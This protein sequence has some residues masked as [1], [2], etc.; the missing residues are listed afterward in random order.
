MTHHRV[1]RQSL[2]LAAAGGL[3]AA[4]LG[5]GPAT[6]ASAAGLPLEP[7]E[8]VVSTFGNLF[9]LPVDKVDPQSGDRSRIANGLP[10][11][12]N[13]VTSDQSGN[14]FVSLRDSS[15][16]RIDRFTG[17]QRRIVVAGQGIFVQDMV[18]D[19]SGQLIV[20]GQTATGP[21]LFSVDPNSGIPT[22]L[23]QNQVFGKITSGLALESDG[24][25]L[26]ADAGNRQIVR[27]DGSTHTASKLATFSAG[28]ELGSLIVA[29]TGEILVRANLSDT[30][31][32]PALVRVD[33][34]T[35][36]KQ[37]LFKDSAH[38]RTNT[39]MARNEEGTIY[40][41]ERGLEDRTKS[42]VLVMSAP[43]KS[44]TILD[45]SGDSDSLDV[46]VAGHRQ[47][48]PVPN[49]VGVA[50]RFTLEQPIGQFESPRS[51]LS[52]D[53]N[54]A[55]TP[56][57]AEKV[58]EVSHG[59][60][61]FFSDGRFF[62]FP[63]SGF[64]GT[65]TLT[66]RVRAGNRLSAPTTVTFTVLPP[67]APVAKDDFFL[68]PFGKTLIFE[69]DL[70]PLLN[71]S[72]PQGDPVSARV[73][74]QAQHGLASFD[75]DNTM[76]YLP[77]ANFSGTDSFTYQLTDGKH[78]SNIATVT[79]TVGNPPPAN[80]APSIAVSTG[81]SINS[82]GTGATVKLTISDPETG[83]NL[84]GLA[85]S[86]SNTGLLPS[87]GLV[88]GGTANARTLTVT[89]KA[90]AIGTATVTV[91]VTD[92]GGLKKSLPVTVKVD[93]GGDHTLA[94]TEGTDVLFGAGG[95]DTLSGAGGIDLLSGAAGDDTMTG[96]AGADVFR[97]GTGINKVTDL[98]T[99]EGDSATEV[100]P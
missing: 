57:T 45:R 37:V 76:A 41:T 35:G 55:G 15:I 99:A 2:A 36:L 53:L 100:T 27:V 13:K 98:K 29:D 32:T 8:L 85:A 67:Q 46:T 89:P 68:T 34:L 61:S 88:F 70:G 77:A 92:G 84:L 3:V 80:K 94:G 56:M 64:S 14:V 66:Y 24:D 44:V 33:P 79:I 39:G 43:F 22:L 48:P 69:P 10:E 50:D 81:G 5:L 30:A 78:K 87:S 63:T 11:R 97:G 51:V 18:V 96:G 71:D 74:T 20:V 93:D 38:L 40:L 62:Y 21:G 86:S 7:G 95:K 58:T 52:N 91:T 82:A 42:H 83:A 73:I 28:T 23:V 1:R 72:D 90:G 47:V 17:A 60:T 26:I 65:D 9:D 16:L 75:S 54:L 25:L 19:G 4:A 6:P 31:H 49:P 12:S 59:F